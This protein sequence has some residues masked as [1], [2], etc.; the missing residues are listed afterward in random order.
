M[1]QSDAGRIDVVVAAHHSLFRRSLVVMLEDADDIDVVGELATSQELERTYPLVLPDVVMVAL[2]VTGELDSTI[3]ALSPRCLVAGV[4]VGDVDAAMTVLVA[5]AHAVHWVED[6]LVSGRE[7]VHDAYGGGSTVPDE[8]ATTLGDA[9][10][11]FATST[12]D[13]DLCRELTRGLSPEMAA[14]ELGVDAT[15]GGRRIRNLVVRLQRRAA[16]DRLDREDGSSP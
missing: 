16:A 4:P 6:L 11:S 1:K 12:R 10:G 7:A 15:E 9:L 3:R 13:V 14:L 8:V 5:G 2:E